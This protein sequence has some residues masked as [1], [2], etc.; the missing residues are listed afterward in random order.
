MKK[1]D[2][3]REFLESYKGLVL[4]AKRLGLS[5]RS[6]WEAATGVTS[7]LSGMPR[8]N[9]D[10]ESLKVALAQASQDTERRLA[11]ALWKRHEV[12]RFL[13]GI[14]NDVY[15]NLLKMRYV[16]LL[17][18]PDIVEAFEDSGI[19]YCDRNIFNLHGYALDAARELWKKNHPEDME[20]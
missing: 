7:N 10:S 2:R 3:C 12:E 13:D 19:P 4:E 9:G 5:A 17:R 20:D 15:R 8:S 14:E 16:D 1:P 18:W 6:L 11:E